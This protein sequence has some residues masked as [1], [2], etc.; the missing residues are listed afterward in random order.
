MNRLLRPIVHH[1]SH[2]ALLWPV[3]R[4]GNGARL[5]AVIVPSYR[6]ALALREA[7]R[8]ARSMRATLVV[9][10]SG[11]AQAADA[12]AV[13]G[14]QPGLRLIAIDVPAEHQLP[15]RGFETAAITRTLGIPPVDTGH[16]RNLGL[17]LA[18]LLNWRRVIFL[19]D[20]VDVDDLGGVRQA[21][22]L[23]D[24]YPS[25]GLK[26]D[27]FPDNSMVCHAHRQAGGAQAIFV[28]GG[29]LAVDVRR[30][31]SF[32]PEIYNE[33][34]FFLLDREGLRPVTQTG[35]VVHHGFDPFARPE[36]AADQEFGDVLAEGIYWQLDETGRFDGCT[37]TFWD[38]FLDRR[39]RFIADVL[40]RT[41]YLDSTRIQSTGQDVCLALKHAADR[42]DR[43]T[44]KDCTDY[45]MAWAADRASWQRLWQAQPQ[46][47]RLEEALDRLDLSGLVLNSAPRSSR[48]SVPSRR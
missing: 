12:V 4:P 1:G 31:V 17:L 3:R 22:G 39:R 38:W 8:V 33:D 20:D 45:L 32:F 24:S 48:S 23:L 35:A 40:R 30:D 11:A 41:E 25:V 29:A 14:A 36:V 19:D 21:I 34:W 7:A 44:P 26:I 5:D 28:G 47:I 13:L 37:E 42:A 43:L 15:I 16:K 27:G 2:R 18:R 6:P 9:L 46:Q 10:A